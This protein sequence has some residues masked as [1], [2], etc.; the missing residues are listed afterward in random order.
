M[1]DQ[2]FFQLQTRLFY[3]IGYSRNL[4]GMIKDNGYRNVAILVDE[5][6]FRTLPYYQEI[7]VVIQKAA[8]RHHIEVLRG[9]EE[10]DYEYLDEI[11]DKVRTIDTIDVIVGIGGGSCLDITKA[12]AVL[13]TNPGK[14]IEYRGFDKVTTPGV[15]TIAIPTTAGTGSEV[16]NN[17]VFTDKKEM[18]KL[19]I[20]GRFMNASYA[21]LDG[22]WT[23]SCPESVAVSSGMDAL[24]HSLES[25]MCNKA[26]P[27]TRTFSKAAFARLY[28][29]LPSI[30]DDP[31]NAMKRQELLLGSFFAAIALFNSGSGIAGA[32]SYPLGVYFKV[33]HGIGGGIFLPSVIE[34][35]VKRG[36]EDYAELFDLIEPGSK[37]P[38]KEKAVRFSYLLKA[39]SAKLGVP[40]YLN[41]W[42]I[43]KKNVGEVSKLMLPLQAAF[44]QNP[45]AFSAE[46][47]AYEMLARHVK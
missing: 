9:T 22:E 7:Q 16:T 45:V 37:V 4:G 3:G 21:I 44:D 18:K 33:P 20:N 34:F 23:M 8:E 39:L 35:N 31:L 30:I 10:P 41:Q 38:V 47:D 43:T 14:S 46:K 13:K 29:A 11:T 1:M 25:F 40:E 32:L 27:L 26:N 6:V 19:G 12:V 17:A 24:V 28:H 36:Y 15:P 2:F 5:G 42:G